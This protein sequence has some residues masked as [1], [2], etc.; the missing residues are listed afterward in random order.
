MSIESDSG[1]AKS[2]LLEELKVEG[3][4]PESPSEKWDERGG[5]EIPP[6][7]LTR[8]IEGSHPTPGTLN[9]QRGGGVHTLTH[10]N[11]PPPPL[12][13]RYFALE[14][15][16]CKRIITDSKELLIPNNAGG[17]MHINA[18]HALHTLHAPHTS[19]PLVYSD[20][21]HFHIFNNLLN[22]LDLG[23]EMKVSKSGKKGA[24]NHSFYYSV[25]CRGCGSS[26]GRNYIS[27]N[28]KIAHIN[29]KYAL[30]K[31]RINKVAWGN[32]G[33]VPTPTSS[34]PIP[35]PLEG[36]NH[37]LNLMEER[38]FK[39]AKISP[40]PSHSRPLLHSLKHINLGR[41]EREREHGLGH[42]HQHEHEHEHELPREEEIDESFNIFLGSPKMRGHRHRHKSSHA[43]SKSMEVRKLQMDKLIDR[44]TNLINEAEGRKKE[45]IK[46]Q[47]TF[48][49]GIVELL[50]WVIV[51]HEKLDNIHNKIDNIPLG[52][53]GI[54]GGNS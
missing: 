12:L 21:R 54:M 49:Q 48:Q 27:A 28:G 40:E 22:T 13:P 1:K 15:G 2:E 38:Q 32:I 17:L 23:K 19:S 51:I 25:L 8:D 3:Y 18:P 35:L 34:S 44:L 5:V 46:K 50:N 26:I 39:S 30:I 52:N 16:K 36:R 20:D 29:N 14:C 45:E 24:E 47:E 42:Q 7:H 43:H 6:G 53:Q 10:H 33:S 11:H 4:I 9:V 37:R 31:S 41:V